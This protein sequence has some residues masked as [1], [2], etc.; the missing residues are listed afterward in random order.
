MRGPGRTRR[1]SNSARF[2]RY[3][4]RTSDVDAAKSFYDDVLG[5]DLWGAD[6]EV[7]PLHE[8]A[9]A[10][11]ARPHWLGHLGVGDFEGIT[12]RFVA[13]GAQQLGPT[14]HGT[15]G[16]YVVLRDP[17]GAIIAV[18]SEAAGP[19]RDRV[20]WHL[21]HTRDRERAVSAYG[22][23]FGWRPT[24]LVDLGPELGLHQGFAWDVAGG[25]AGYIS[26]AARSPGIHA[27]W[28]YAFRVPDLEQALSTVRARGGI[29]L[30]TVRIGRGETV[31]PCDDPQGAAFALLQP[32][33]A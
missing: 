33:T 31:A 27:Q 2:V 17:F 7:Y 4:L 23:L 21:L 14:V 10:R 22:G 28:L 3:T 5:A 32:A 1:S 26:D 29:A 25:L 20:V 11:G 6:V 30:A 15:A 8:Q 12:A 19:P 13:L 18:S 9:I 24:E 16:T